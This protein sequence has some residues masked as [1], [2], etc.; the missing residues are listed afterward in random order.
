M[1]HFA[2]PG[3]SAAI[4]HAKAALLALVGAAATGMVFLFR[5]TVVHCCFGSLLTSDAATVAMLELAD[6]GG[7][8]RAGVGTIVGRDGKIDEPKKRLLNREA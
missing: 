5:S 4:D 2:G 7:Y 8:V 1:R 3:F 6:G